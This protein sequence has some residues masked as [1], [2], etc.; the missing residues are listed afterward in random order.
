ML[1]GN[2]AM[3]QSNE[4][5]RRTPARGP[6]GKLQNA[7]LRSSHLPAKSFTHSSSG[8]IGLHRESPQARIFSKRQ[9]TTTSKLFYAVW[10]SCAWAPSSM[11]HGGQILVNLQLNTTTQPLRA[12]GCDACSDL[13]SNTTR[14]DED[15]VY[16]IYIYIY[17]Y[18]YPGIL[19]NIHRFPWFP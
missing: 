16:N 6:K 14:S 11:Q 5:C 4:R 8:R 15:Y 1:W 19:V 10:P 9:P 13:H 7:S 2:E 3:R 18:I 12:P 17:I